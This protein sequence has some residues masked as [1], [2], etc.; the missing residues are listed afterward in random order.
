MKKTLGIALV[1][2]VVSLQAAAGA[3]A[4]PGARADADVAAMLKKQMS[5]D[6]DAYRT[7]DSVA[8]VTEFYRKQGLKEL[9]G[10]S[11]ESAGFTTKEGPM[12]TIQN[13]WMDMKTGKIMN[14]TLVIIPK[15]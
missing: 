4:Y 5:M 2:L 14:D 13:P 8:K 15:K 9:P 10:T 1:S 12:M 6:A 7:N 3:P 11:K